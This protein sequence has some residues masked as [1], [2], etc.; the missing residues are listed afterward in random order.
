MNI[1]DIL[2]VGLLGDMIAQ[3]YVSERYHNDL[4]LVIFNYT[5]K[6]QWE[7]AWNDVTLKTRGLIVNIDTHEVISRP[8]EKFFNW[9]QGRFYPPTGPV[10]RME[11][12]DGS[13]GIL[14]HHTI[15][16][17]HGVQTEY[18]IATRGSFHSEQAE[19]ATN[20]Y[21]MAE[22]SQQMDFVPLHEKTYLFE[23]IFPG[24]RIVVDYGEYEG[25]VLIDVIDDETG[26]SDLQEFDDCGWPEKVNRVPMASFSE[27]QIVDI[28]PGDEGFVYL[29]PERNVRTKMKA[30]DY[31]EL[32]R[33]ISHLSEKSVWEALVSG[34][35]IAQIKEGVPDEFYGFIDETANAIMEKASEIVR[36]A[37]AA[38]YEVAEGLPTDES[39]KV[40]R[41]AFA[42]K[43]S[44]HPLKKYLFMV[45][46]SKPVYPV[47][48]VESKPVANRSL[49]SQED[50]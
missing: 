11:K 3:G 30:P 33:L 50:I 49:I 6:T 23:I 32:H 27:T 40:N 18:G 16:T 26:K 2:D 43:A 31:V 19:W 46:D 24:N 25:L 38:F 39:G 7:W 17:T 8:F 10:I 1:N 9:D 13:L 45:L 14:Y 15:P 20:F 28:P 35:T 12:M 22:A 29:W 4:P 37:H 5:P 47:A 21:G 41:K 44:K 42:L 36:E 34:K 48:L